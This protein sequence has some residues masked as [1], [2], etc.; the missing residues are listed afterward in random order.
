MILYDGLETLLT[1][2]DMTKTRLR[3]LCGMSS[4]TM[5]KLAKNEYVSLE[6][7]ESICR[8]LSCQPGDILRLSEEE[9]PRTFLDA[10]LSERENSEEVSAYRETQI[11]FAYN[12]NRLE[13]SSLT[14]EQTRG[15]YNKDT[16]KNKAEKTTRVSDIL[17]AVNH[18]K[19][20]DYILD[21]AEEQPE[22]HVIRALYRI[23]ADDPDGEKP[24]IKHKELSRLL[25]SY[26]A[27]RQ[28]SLE[29]L[30]A[31]HSDFVTLA[32]LRDFNGQIARLI[33]YKECLRY[34]IKPFIIDAGKKEY[35]ERGIREFHHDS[36][37]LVDLFR[38]WQE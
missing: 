24:I 20:F 14:E 29:D 31:F 16:L 11:L 28:A 26:R 8:V 25:K 32:P 12:S 17:L 9:K 15:I 22:E 21:V 38:G 10:L 13:G 5:A 2:R 36:E 3:E 27:V 30:A 33:L 19:C 35:Y 7:I 4:R 1:D 23:M 6:T 18:F 37:C 34:N